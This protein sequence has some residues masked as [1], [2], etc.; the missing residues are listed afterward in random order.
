MDI[1]IFV[2]FASWFSSNPKKTSEYHIHRNVALTLIHKVGFFH[3]LIFSNSSN[4]DWFYSNSPVQI[5]F[6][7]SISWSTSW[8]YPFLECCNNDSVV[9]CH[10]Y[11]ISGSWTYCRIIRYPN[12]FISYLLYFVKA[13]APISDRFKLEYHS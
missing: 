12:F 8:A 6:N 5:I 10:S 4:S 7:R 3:S 11:R 1:N 13:V 9:K 2:D